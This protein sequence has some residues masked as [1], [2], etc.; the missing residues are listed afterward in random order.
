MSDMLKDWIDEGTRRGARWLIINWDARERDWTRH[1]ASGRG[2][3]PY[4]CGLE[5]EQFR[6]DLH[7]DPATSAGHVYLAEEP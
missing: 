1:Y 2:P 4:K 6:V 3:V 7:A 5:L